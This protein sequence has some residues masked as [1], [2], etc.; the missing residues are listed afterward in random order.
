[1]LS[2]IMA[3]DEGRFGRNG[4]VMKSLCL[5]GVRPLVVSA[6]SAGLLEQIGTPEIVYTQPASPFVAEFVTQANL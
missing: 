3:Q 1:M 5:T 4:Q 6:G 2:L